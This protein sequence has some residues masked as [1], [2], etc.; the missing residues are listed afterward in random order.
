MI[1]IKENKCDFCGTCV[2][3][4]PVDAIEMAEADLKIIHETCIDCDICVWVC[5]IDVLE[6]RVNPEEE[7]VASD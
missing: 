6:S 3:V 2:A 7:E 4:C 5:P 1:H